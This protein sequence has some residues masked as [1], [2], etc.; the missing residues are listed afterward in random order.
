M[1][2]MPHAGCEGYCRQ[3]QKKS[4]FFFPLIDAGGASCN[5]HDPVLRLRQ[6]VGFLALPAA[7]FRPGLLSTSLSPATQQLACEAAIKSGREARGKHGEDGS[8]E[9]SFMCGAPAERAAGADRSP[10]SPRCTSTRVLAGPGLVGEAGAHVAVRV[11]STPIYPYRC[12]ERDAT[13][14]QSPVACTIQA[15]C[16]TARAV[17]VREQQHH[18]APRNDHA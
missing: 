12:A 17:E 7:A 2:I 8:H 6:L 15:S 1:P 3:C 11:G 9:F 4:H 16:I 5:S 13:V 10:A 18:A 14:E